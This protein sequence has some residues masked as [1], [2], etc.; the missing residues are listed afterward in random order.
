LWIAPMSSWVV[1]S[2]A[3]PKALRLVA[4]SLVAEIS[5]Q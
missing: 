2:G 3:V 1:F 4:L 5:S